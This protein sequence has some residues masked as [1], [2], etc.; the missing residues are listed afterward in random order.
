MDVELFDGMWEDMSIETV[1]YKFK[2]KRIR[3]ITAEA[4]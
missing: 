4:V 2:N 1:M 3:N